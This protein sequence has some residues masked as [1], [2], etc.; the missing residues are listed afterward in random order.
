M[1]V[2]DPGSHSLSL[3]APHAKISRFFSFSYFEPRP[4]MDREQL[5]QMSA[6]RFAGITIVKDCRAL[7]GRLGVGGADSEP[8]EDYGSFKTF[9]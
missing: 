2:S 9:S 3:H 1:L 6:K 7:R 4:S 8:P 5:V